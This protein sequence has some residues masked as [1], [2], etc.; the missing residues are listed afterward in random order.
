MHSHKRVVDTVV[1]AV[2]TGGMKMDALVTDTPAAITG[3][4]HGNWSE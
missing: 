4:L 3:Y 2:W 1:K